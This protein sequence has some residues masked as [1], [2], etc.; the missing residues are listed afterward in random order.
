MKFTDRARSFLGD[1][2]DGIACRTS[3]AVKYV[4]KHPASFSIAA[5]ALITT[6]VLVC[7]FVPKI[8]NAAHNNDSRD[9]NAHPTEETIVIPTNVPTATP[10]ATPTPSPTP[11]PTPTPV[12]LFL[13]KGVRNDIVIDVQQRL[14]ELNYMDYDEPTNYYGSITTE[15]VKLFQRRNKIEVTGKM[16]ESVYSLL[17]SSRAKIYMASK[18]DE[19]TDIE[20]MQKRLHELD[21]LKKVTG[22]FDDDTEDAVKLF[23]KKNELEI[24]GMVGTMTKE[25]LYSEDA[26]PNSLYI[27]STGDEVRKLQNRLWTL[28]YL[29]S[30]PDGVYGEDTVAAVKRFQS[31]NDLIVD[32][33]L[34][35]NTKRMLTSTSAKY[36]KLE[37]TMSGDDVQRVQ[38]RLQKLNYLKASEVTGYFGAITEQAVRVFQKNNGL[39]VDGKV[40]KETYEKLFSSDAKRAARPVSSTPVPTATPKPTKTPKP[41]SSTTKPKTHKPGSS[42]PTPKPS[43]STGGTSTQDKINALI[44]IA[45]SKLGCPYIRGAK[46]P[47]S[48]DCSGFVYWCLNKAG[49][50][51]SY[52]TSYMW[53]TTSRYPRIGSLSSVKAGDIIVYKMGAYSGHVAIAVGN[54]MMID[55]SSSEGKVVYRSYNTSYWRQVFYCAYRV[56]GN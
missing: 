48:F 22:V 21:Y 1:L 37:F 47:N 11:A 54:G 50:Q 46:G 39:S 29:P 27:G 9:A 40:A 43:S 6:I 5:A 2:F 13:E 33:Y 15:A 44:R 16:D 18:G 24:D 7:V 45:R 35:P 19:G 49:V 20:E 12:P 14:M 42:T 28:G 31:R 8:T 34:G 23:Q 10:T 51:Q 30:K 17:M 56:F 55:A 3:T 25:C 41:G 36:N 38:A 26:V 52:M 32:G 4:K 53:R